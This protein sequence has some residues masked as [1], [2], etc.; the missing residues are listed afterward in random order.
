LASQVS[1]IESTEA[2]HS[3]ESPVVW[4]LGSWELEHQHEVGGVTGCGEDTLSDRCLVDRS[5]VAL[6]DWNVVCFDW[7]EPEPWTCCVKDLWC[8]L[9]E[10]EALGVPSATFKVHTSN[11]HTICW[12]LNLRFIRILQDLEVITEQIDSDSVLSGIVLLVGCQET[13]SKEESS[14]PKDTWET[15]L[16]P[17]L[18]PV[19]SRH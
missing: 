18:E 4:M 9:S 10:A 6:A 11:K 7:L 19:K 13:M 2:C 14:D 3:S 17:V 1:V 5:H 8:R 15:C 16:Q 12:R